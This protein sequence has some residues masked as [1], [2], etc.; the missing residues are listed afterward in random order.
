VPH[1]LLL[2]GNR[3]SDRVQPGT[4]GVAHGM[5]SLRR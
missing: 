3:S 2:H 1:Q 4:I 5:G